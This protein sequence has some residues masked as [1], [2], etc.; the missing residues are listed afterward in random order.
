MDR[1]PVAAW[2]VDAEDR[3]VYASEPW[4]LDQEQ[5]G[6]PIFDLV[7]PEFAEP[8]RGALRRAR[9][10]GRAQE[11]TARGPRPE[12]GPD[13]TGWFRAFYFPVMGDLV[14]GFGV[15]ITELVEAREAL[16]ASR[17]RLVAAGDQA[18]RRIERDLHDGVQ[19]HL[20]TQL[21]TLR[22][23]RDLALS[24]AGKAVEMLD[25]LIQDVNETVDEVRNLARGI[26][27]TALTKFGLVAALQGLTARSNLE[28][29]LRCDVDRRLPEAV[30]IAA[31]FLCAESLTN[32]AK[33]SGTS[34]CAIS[35]TLAADILRVENSDEGVGGAEVTRGGGLEGLRDRIEALHGEFVVTEAHPHGTRIVATIPLS[36]DL[37]APVA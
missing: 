31:Y 25:K 37:A 28:V 26:H 32:V 11:I 23:V 12:R 36:T 35:V 19:Q 15:D 13:A 24:D 8:Y 4:P 27:P 22:L 3:L 9:T 16:L 30:E 7:P 18:R 14:G 2:V 33:Y 17:G 10:T 21:L 6:T 34:R 1:I 5:L 29:D 20:I